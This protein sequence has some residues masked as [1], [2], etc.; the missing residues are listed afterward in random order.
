MVSLSFGKRQEKGTEG[1]DEIWEM[2][3]FFHINGNELSGWES[4][5]ILI[6]SAVSVREMRTQP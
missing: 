4:F 2:I 1:N 6:N 5:A 3:G